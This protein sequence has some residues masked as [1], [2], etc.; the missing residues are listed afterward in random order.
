MRIDDDA[1]RDTA[2]AGALPGVVTAVD[3]EP[4]L[5]QDDATA[6]GRGTDE[7]A[8]GV[9]HLGWK[10]TIL[11]AGALVL[12]YGIG[13]TGL[14]IGVAMHSPA[15][16]VVVFI[17][18]ALGG[19]VV[20]RRWIDTGTLPSSAALWVIGGGIVILGLGLAIL[21]WTSDWSNRM[22]FVV[23]GLGAA[24][25]S[26]GQ[27]LADLRARPARVDDLRVPLATGG[28]L[29]G[30]F[31]AGA[32]WLLVAPSPY[33]LLPMVIALV[34][35]PVS[36]SM[37][38]GGLLRRLLGSSWMRLGVVGGCGLALVVGSLLLLERSGVSGAYLW[39]IAVVVFLLL[40]AITSNTDLDVIGVTALVAVIASLAPKGA[41]IDSAITQAD[42]Q[43]VVVAIGDSYMSGEGARAFY[44]GTNSIGTNECR[45]APGAYPALL[46]SRTELIDSTVFVACSG[47]KAVHMVDEDGDGVGDRQQQLPQAE[48]ALAEHPVTIDTVLLS[49]GG[50]DSKFSEVA[51]TCLAP[52]DCTE[53]AQRWLD[54]LPRTAERLAAFYA[55]VA[56][57]FPGVPTVVMPYPIPITST[58]CAGS[59]FS[60]DEHAFLVAF[61]EELDAVVR[62]EAGRAGFHYLAPI[63]RL[64]E[65]NGLRICDSE[66]AAD[67]GVNFLS[68]NPADGFAIDRLN[69]QNWIHNSL[70]PNRLGHFAMFQA[71]A[72]YFET[73]VRRAWPLV[74]PDAE[75][76]P[77]SLADILGPGH[78]YC[79]GVD[80]PDYCPTSA[81][82][83]TAVQAGL[84]LVRAAMPLLFIAG[85][86]WLLWLVLLSL[87]FRITVAPLPDQPPPDQ[88]PPDQPPPDQPPPGQAGA[89]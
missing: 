6:A 3:T 63:E 30:V 7:D 82:D 57:A 45:R 22:Y 71:L 59:G 9:A 26:T 43:R 84:S 81:T 37:I 46:A 13:L 11:R 64:F 2:S 35:A 75:W 14:L 65:R 55:D 16:V 38:T 19:F 12:Y 23:G 4:E 51:A 40:G 61:T 5:V 34:V 28:V 50:N 80:E 15:V 8:E 72:P 79:G 73:D 60:D 54:A 58:G 56:A 77:R 47:A 62:Q 49:M 87:R 66:D 74:N 20:R 17:V 24:F 29:A 33:A 32:A 67:V 88:P 41:P 70:H 76:T 1:T 48:A 85:G 36:L 42:G 31:A 10:A 39:I 27:M 21:G 18:F 89:D 83:W 44:E 25:V 78:S 68:R 53:I 52:G 69:P 86:C